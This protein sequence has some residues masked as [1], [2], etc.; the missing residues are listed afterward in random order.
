MID[1]VQY[2]MLARLEQPFLDIKQLGY[3]ELTVLAGEVRELIIEV[4]S[5]NGGHIAPSLG[6]VELTIALLRVFNPDNDRII[7]DVG[8]QSYP[9]KI[10]TDRRDRF[11]TLR[12]F[13]GISGFSNVS[14]SRYDAFGTGHAST[15][16]SAGV[17]M[18]CADEI[19]KNARHVISVIGDGSLTGGMAFEGL[20]A[21]GSTNKPMIVILNDNEMSIGKNV[22]ALS[23]MLSR[24][25]TGESVSAV[26][27]K[28]KNF[29]ENAPFGDRLKRLAKRFEESVVSLFTPGILFEELGLRYVGPIDGHNV[30]GIEDALKVALD[31]KCPVLLHITTIKG[32]GFAP[33]E[34]HPE[35][36]HSS[37]SF[38]RATGLQDKGGVGSSW[39]D[40]FG[41]KML[42]LGERDKRVMAVTAAM[43][44]GVG[45]TKYAKAFPDRFFDVGIA[46]EHATTFAAGLAISGL[47]PY[48]A[49]YSTFLQR[50][51]D[52]IIHDVALQKLPVRFCIDR[53]GLVG[54]DG[55]T[56]HGAFDISY[57]RIIPNMNI[58]LPRDTD[59]LSEMLELS[60]DWQN[61]PLAI[62]YPRGRVILDDS[63]PK[64][65]LALGEPEVVFEGNG[66]IV[67]VSAGHMF[68]EANKFYNKLKSSGINPTLVNL[69]FLSPLNTN[70]LVELTGS[71]KHVWSFEENVRA[72]G[73]GEM[74]TCLLATN[75]STAHVNIMSLPN[76]FV[77]HGNTD[78]LRESVE[79]T[80][81]A[82]YR[83][84]CSQ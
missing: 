48:V 29:I 13:N 64:Q 21:L 79:L 14:E 8:H 75:K 30:R 52:Q 70:R 4:V 74:L 47:K 49:I 12:Q 77:T 81:D 71:A 53:A 73:V 69:R 19:L 44:D 80:A 40:K 43:T 22:G 1:K 54:N 25:L 39:T 61:L 26:R 45:L 17:G 3:S 38:D 56:H 9:Y 55:A 62:R 10:L 2:P 16:V 76:S 34:E 60:L 57:L 28:L 35:N 83:L 58:W 65:K 24:I 68:S 23:A 51:F 50:A 36:F 46:E 42:E 6:V 15:S 84:F 72:G 33:A 20:N 67:I 66:D 7:W 41:E 63:I 78:K 31:Y 5:K 27:R 37:S 82:A 59:E 32:Y 18:V 11:H